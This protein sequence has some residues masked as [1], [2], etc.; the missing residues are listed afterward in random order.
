MP[1]I[2]GP[3]PEISLR[4]SGLAGFL[5]A[6]GRFL[7]GSAAGWALAGPAFPATELPLRAAA[8]GA[9][10]AVFGAGPL[11]ASAPRDTVLGPDGVALRPARSVS[12]AACFAVF[13]R[14]AVAG[15][16]EDY[17]PEGWATA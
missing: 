13:G 5:I 3:T 14:F 9:F 6:G 15:L 16:V 17:V 10:L 12:D 11:A 8:D 4:S 1:S 7:S 2:F